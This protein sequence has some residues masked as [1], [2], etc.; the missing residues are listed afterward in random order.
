[1]KVKD[2]VSFL[3]IKDV[4]GD[5]TLEITEVDDLRGAKDKALS[6]INDF[7]YLSYL[8]DSKAVFLLVDE[9]IDVNKVKELFLKEG[10]SFIVVKNAYLTF[11]KIINKFF[12]KEEKIQN[13][14]ISPNAKIGKN[15][16]IYP[17]VVVMDGVDI[18]DNC[19]INP[20]VVIYKNVKIGSNVIISAGAI[21]GSDG[22]GYV[23][24]GDVYVKVPHLGSVIIEDNVEIGANSCI[25]RGTILDTIIKKCTKI[26]N[27]VQIG[28]NC[29]IGENN[30]L[31]GM[32][33]L[34]GSTTLGKN[35]TMAANSGT[36]GHIEIGDNVIVT[37]RTSVSKN[38][39]NDVTVKGYPARPLNEEL[40][41][42]TLVG[43]LP[44]IY[45][46]LKKLEEE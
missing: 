5:D 41:I 29:I 24:D 25:D 39:P 35:V 19:I 3:S 28:H 11:I 38:L 4:F 17:G 32:V 22:F 2:L 9:K 27:L 7:N 42:Q 44:E 13:T 45:K 1:M 20:N 10:K 16:K 26:D 36:K 6:F 23:K 18:G 46:R 14:L 31:C 15:T 34:S 8:K 33:G 30:I 40:K 43:K 21:I 12:I 37:A